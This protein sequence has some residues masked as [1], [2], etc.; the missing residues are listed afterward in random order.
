MQLYEIFKDKKCSYIVSEYIDGGELFEEIQRRIR[1]P[2]ELAADTLRQ[3]LGSV[4]YCHSKRIMHRD[5]KPENILVDTITSKKLTIKVIDFGA[6]TN[7]FT[8]KE[9]Q[10]VAGT[11]YYMAP[12]V[13]MKSYDEMCDVWSCGVILYVM[14]SGKPP[15]GGGTQEEVMRQVRNALLSFSDECWTKAS[16]QVKDL[17]RRMIRYPPSARITLQEAY[18]HVWT[19]GKR[20]VNVRVVKGALEKLKS[21]KKVMEEMMCRQNWCCRRWR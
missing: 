7:F 5:L 11:A 17:A 6:A 2:E 9:Y 13:I 18:S 21:Y 16:L 20:E 4:L 12:E 19:Q 14:I 10:P 3:I 1:F 15:F 8:H